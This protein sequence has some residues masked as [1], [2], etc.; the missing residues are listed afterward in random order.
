MMDLDNKLIEHVAKTARLELT[1]DEVKAFL[2]QLREVLDAF[3]KL[4]EA[5]TEGTEPSFQP[6]EMKDVLREDKVS[7]C[8]SQKEALSNSPNTKDGYF[9]GPRAV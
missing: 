2:P 5:D 4:S 7:E 3:S 1:K 8:L 9:K 6:V